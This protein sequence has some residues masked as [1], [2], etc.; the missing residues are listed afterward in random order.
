MKRSLATLAAVLAIPLATDAATTT[1]GDPPPSFEMVHYR[2]AN[3]L[4][5]VLQPDPT[6]TTAVIEV[7]YHVGSKDEVEG[8]TGFAHLFEHLMFTGSKHVKEGELDR[9]L[10][11]AGGWN[12]AT[13]NNDRTNYFEQVPANFVEL[14]LWIEADRMAGLWDAMNA[15][16]LDS[17]RA[18]VKNERR[19][20]YENRPYGLADLAV[21]E[22]LWPAG[23]GNQHPTIGSM[24]DLSA[25]SLEDVE[26]FWRQWYVPS[27][28][29]LVICGGID[30]EATRALVDTYFGWM[31]AVDPPK[32]RTLEE[33]VTPRGAATVLEGKD[34]VEVPKVIVA[35]RTDAPFTD[36]AANMDVVAQILGGGEASRLYQRLVFHDRIA[37]DV[38]VYH[39]DQMLGGELHVEATVRDG[40]D[41]EDVRVAIREE[42]AGIRDG[43][44]SA[45]EVERAQ[46]VIESSRLAG[47]EN[48]ASRAN[49]I[50]G[51]AAYTGDPDHL[52]EELAMLHAVTPETAKA[53][54]V[55]WLGE[56][57]A[58]TM[59]VKPDG[60]K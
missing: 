4:E 43:G 8:R 55:A 54:S 50:A 24:K 5:V 46:R 11:T 37:S 42:L 13:T 21:Q 12:N 3:G 14:A 6:V 29:T 60:A 2:L 22:A 49:A 19:Q 17:Q 31:P 58:V 7:W 56:N 34:R 10:E 59:I 47:L 45:D 25:A 53:A 51:W 36:N 52:A 20:S 26:A 30:V 9:L 33:P 16:V 18:V 57:A 48:I 38:V 27:N 44:P 15:K 35:W 28:A 39:Q 40:V 1:G 23:H 41:P 32:P